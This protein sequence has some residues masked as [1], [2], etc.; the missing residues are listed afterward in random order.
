MELDRISDH[1]ASADNATIFFEGTASLAS[2]TDSTNLV[3]PS[4]PR[5][6]PLK[7]SRTNLHQFTPS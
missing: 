6:R 5:I 7:A 4:T 2:W 3:E 1:D